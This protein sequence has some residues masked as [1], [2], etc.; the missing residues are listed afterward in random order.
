MKRRQFIQYAGASL[1]TTAGLGTVALQ[2]A[3][4]QSGGSVSVQW[5]GHTCFLF[6]GDGR[7]IL[8]NP[9]RAIGCTAGYR[10]PRTEAELVMISSRLFDEG[11][12]EGLPGNPRVLAEP[13]VYAYRGLQIQGIRMEHDRL[14]GRRF[15][16]NVAWRWT[17][18]GLTI[19]HLGG[20]ASPISVEQQ[21]LMG[22]P[23][24]LLVPVGGGAKAY[25]PQEAKQAIQALNP[26][27]VIPTH[28][29]TQAADANACDI[30]ALD[31]FLA[32]M[33]E[34]PVRRNGD[35]VSFRRSDLPETGVKI[36]IFSYRF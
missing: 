1:L 35:S 31:E 12:T 9:F 8:V 33:P 19:L 36:E 6:S 2:T 28:Y 29:R 32:L 15:G 13:G 26:R 21:I 5:L 25:T 22:R 20:A 3:Q 18:S 24:V 16:Q 34:A 4:A 17:Q 10:T 30:G 14:G 23:D 7:R 27:I 11:V